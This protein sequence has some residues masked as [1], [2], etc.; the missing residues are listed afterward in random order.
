LSR[1]TTRALVLATGIALTVP[2]AAEAAKRTVFMGPPPA[3]QRGFQRLGAE[4]N[5]FF[6]SSITIRARDTIAFTPVGFHTAH[7]TRGGPAAALIAPTGAKVSGAIDAA[8][9]PFWFNG[10]DQLGLNPALLSSN[11]GKTLTLRSAP[12]QSG[13]PL[14]DRPRP[15]NLRFPRTGRF[16]YVCDVHPGM[17]GTVRVVRGRGHSARAVAAR[18]RGQLAAA[19][20]TARR[21]GGTRPPANTVSVGAAGRGG[22]EIMD[23]LP[24]SLTVPVGTT[25]R[26]TMPA[27][28]TEDHTATSGPGNPMTEP[29]SYLGTIAA[30]FQSPVF[31]PRATYPSERPPAIANLTPQLHGNG[32][33]N[34]GVLDARGATPPPGAAAVRF[35]AAGTYRFF[36]MI[37]PFMDATITAQ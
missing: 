30:S 18:V 23:F 31:D 14:A 20:S 34:S 2:A 1:R 25:V 10:L 16:T 13:L 15:M 9:A 4:V 22:V 35:A 26:F 29:G 32:F 33:W 5:A 19:R 27:R 37:H 11:F 17:R 21:L 8:G 36:C 3:S 7:F 12:V 6:P 24:G 28:S